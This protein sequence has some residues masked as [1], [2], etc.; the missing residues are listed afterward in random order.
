MIISRCNWQV[1]AKSSR[2]AELELQLREQAHQ[3]SVSND[4][5][6]RLAAEKHESERLVLEA[7]MRTLVAQ[8]SSLEAELKRELHPCLPSLNFSLHAL[9]APSC[10]LCPCLHGAPAV[11][12]PAPSIHVSPALPYR[13]AKEY[14]GI[15]AEG[16]RRRPF[17]QGCGRQG[18]ESL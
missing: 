14:R 13:R 16:R 1:I 18:P 2:I 11:P 4:E 5:N 9:V 3:M 7:Q 8:I 12:S 15:A 6:A 17:S 10:R